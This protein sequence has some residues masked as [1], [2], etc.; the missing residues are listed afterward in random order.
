MYVMCVRET[1]HVGK[2]VA[3]TYIEWLLHVHCIYIHVHF[4]QYTPAQYGKETRG[5]CVHMSCVAF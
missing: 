1:V 4:H 5:P 2:F 3:N